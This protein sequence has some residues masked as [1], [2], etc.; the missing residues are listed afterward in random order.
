MTQETLQSLC[1]EWQKTLR[2][3]DWKVTI[4]VWRY[5][6]FSDSLCDANIRIH[7]QHK[8]AELRVL[9]ERD[10]EAVRTWSYD[11]ELFIVHELLH[12]HLDRTESPSSD[13]AEV[14]INLIAEALVNLKRL[15]AAK[16]A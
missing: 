6:Q 2:L 13:D 1:E 14:A 12:I 8:V 4:E 15:Q 3:S 10:H 5:Y 11:F 16:G 9:D 7:R